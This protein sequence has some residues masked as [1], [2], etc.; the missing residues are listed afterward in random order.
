MLGLRQKLLIAF[1]G[2]SLLLLAVAGLGTVVI[3]K[4]SLSF[5]RIF[6]ENLASIDAAR[7]MR[8]AAEEMDQELLLTLWEGTALDTAAFR[9]HSEIFGRRLYFQHG[10]I[11]VTGEREATDSLE[12]CWKGLGNVLAPLLAASTPLPE[13]RRIYLE[14]VRPRLRAVQRQTSVISELNSRNILSADG[15]VRAEARAARKVMILLLLGAGIMV[16]AF[17]YLLGK[18]ILK[19]IRA[20]TRSA[21]E[22]ERGNLDLALAVRSRDELGQLATAFNAM[23]AKLREFRRTDQA[24]LIRTQQ[25]TQIAINSLPDAVAVINAEGFVELSNDPAQALFGI[26]PGTNV[27]TLGLDWLDLLFQKVGREQRPFNPEG[28]QSAVQVFP[29]GKENF[30]LPHLIPILDGSRQ[31]HGVTVVLANVTDLRKLDE[32]KSDLLATVSH[33]LKT[34]LTSVRMA[35]HL[36]LDEKVGDLTGRQ[37]DLLMTAREDTERLHRIIEGLLDI[38]R[39]RSGNLKMRLQPMDVQDLILQSVESSRHAFQDKGLKLQHRI[40]ADLPKILGDPSR[41]HLV[42][43]NLLAN[44]QKYTPAGGQV[45]VRAARSADGIAISVSDTGAGIPAADLPRVFEKFYRGARE[46]EPGGAGLGL[47]IAKEVAE[48]HGGG[49]FVESAEGKGTTFTFVLKPAED[50]KGA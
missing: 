37:A 28:Y 48:A 14:Q 50:G 13:R 23:A 41:I 38:G 25:T 31:L 39:I 19:P 34:R 18:A 15:Q 17:F 30:F 12:R 5:D 42:L 16:L 3:G 32:S 29:N 1:A 33:E 45:E 24:K 46:G 2:L 36:L 6:H 22:I 4:V 40:D 21:Q 47:A 10:N 7:E 27:A 44:A 9:R 49:I 35:V 8:Q 26:K 20:L 43:A 11:T